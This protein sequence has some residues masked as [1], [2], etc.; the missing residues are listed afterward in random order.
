MKSKLPVLITDN[1]YK[2]YQLGKTEIEV[3]KGI[4]FEIFEGEIVAVTGPSGVGKSTLLHILGVLDHP[5]SGNLYIDQEDVFQLDNNKLANYRNKTVGFVFQFHHLLQEFSALENVMLPGMIADTPKQELQ[6]H[7]EHLLAEVG[8]TDRKHHRPSE[9]SGGEQQRVAVARALINSPRIILADEPSGNLDRSS[10]GSLHEL[11]WK[12][13]EKFQQTL[14][15]VTH[16]LELATNADRV[17][18]LYDGQVKT[19]TLN[20]LKK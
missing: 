20:H 14:V 2:S 12:L 17:I 3:L 15:I 11:F 6:D 10:A 4:D 1:V 7:A 16:N 19:N 9:M 5:S 13:N 18:E 8:L